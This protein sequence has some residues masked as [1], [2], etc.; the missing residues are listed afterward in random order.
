[1][2]ASKFNEL[3]RRTLLTAIGLCAPRSTAANKAGIDERT[4]RTWLDRGKTD[5]Q[6]N[7]LDE[8]E[9]AAEFVAFRKEFLKAEAE[10]EHSLVGSIIGAAKSRFKADWKAAAW[11]LERRH[12]DRWGY[13]ASLEH[14][15]EVTAN[16]VT[17]VVMLPPEETD[18][19]PGSDGTVET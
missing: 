15:G 1:M 13:K 14:S 7:P 5:D 18:D 4:L 10:A 3:T 6:G 12:S 11:L 19:D 2:S 9:D 17:G 16:V 8:R